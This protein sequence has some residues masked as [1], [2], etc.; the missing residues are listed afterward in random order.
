MTIVHRSHE[1]NSLA[2][3]RQVDDITKQMVDQILQGP[4]ERRTIQDGV[5]SSCS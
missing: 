3:A 1:K 2:W 4:P 5:G